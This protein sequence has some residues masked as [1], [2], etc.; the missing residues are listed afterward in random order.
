MSFSDKRKELNEQSIPIQI[1]LVKEHLLG[2][3]Y[4]VLTK[5]YKDKNESFNIK[6]INLLNKKLK[7]CRQIGLTLDDIKVVLQTSDKDEN[8][9]FELEP[10][11]QK[12][13]RVFRLLENY[14]VKQISNY[15]EIDNLP[16]GY[17]AY[18]RNKIIYSLQRMFNCYRVIFLKNHKYIVQFNTVE[19]AY[20]ALQTYHLSEYKDKLL[21]VNFSASISEGEKCFSSM[22]SVTSSMLKE[23][24]L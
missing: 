19:E 18:S 12:K 5:F 2:N 24:E 20:D 8:S 10:I 23:L 6:L 14:K 11:L 7:I 4:K 22:L 15:L 21:V 17:N 1:K 16:R 3:F 13:N 9:L